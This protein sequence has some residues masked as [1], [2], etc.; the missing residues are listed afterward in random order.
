MEYGGWLFDCGHFHQSDFL[1]IARSHGIC[2]DCRNAGKILAQAARLKKTKTS[3]EPIFTTLTGRVTPPKKR[4]L[5][6]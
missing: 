4:R 6:C 2:N 3:Q 5:D 1:Q